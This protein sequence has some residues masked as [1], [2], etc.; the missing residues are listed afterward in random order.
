MFEVRGSIFK[1]RSH[2]RSPAARGASGARGA[3][4]GGEVGCEG[5]AGR[6]GGAGVETISAAACV[7]HV[8]VAAPS[9]RAGRS[10][11]PCPPPRPPTRRR[12]LC[13]PTHHACR[14]RAR[15]KGASATARQPLQP[16]APLPLS[17]FPPVP[18]LLRRPRAA[19]SSCARA[20]AASVAVRR[21]QLP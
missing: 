14:G 12:A 21:R 20:E 17:R 15:E 16:H 11:S 19:A 13:T 4:G 2:D 7:A 8:G 6:Q 3:Q 9:E 10:S 18:P 5:G 1:W